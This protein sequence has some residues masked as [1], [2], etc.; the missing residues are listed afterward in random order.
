MDRAPDGQAVSACL[1]LAVDCEDRAATTVE[2]P[3]CGITRRSGSDG[4]VTVGALTTLSELA[5]HPIIVRDYAALSQA[6]E[7]AATPQ[8]R[9]MAT[10]GGNLQRPHCLY[11]RNNLFS[12]WLKGGDTIQQA[13]VVMSGVS[14]VPWRAH[15]VEAVLVG[16]QPSDSLFAR[17]GDAAVREAQPLEHN[18]YEVPLDRNLI[19]RAPADLAQQCPH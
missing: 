6:V 11:Y 1:T 10:S 8:L 9:N 13:R 12:S 4:G 14:T 19:I 16:Q 17:A 3:A 7:L 18:A 15:V 2:G 5:S